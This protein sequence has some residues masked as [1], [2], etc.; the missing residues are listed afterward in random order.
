VDIVKCTRLFQGE[1]VKNER[2]RSHRHERV[3]LV[4]DV[5]PFVTAVWTLS[6]ARACSRASQ[7][8]TSEFARTVMKGLS[9][10]LSP[11]VNHVALPFFPHSMLMT[12]AKLVLD[13][14]FPTFTDTMLVLVS[15]L[16]LNRRAFAFPPEAAVI[17]VRSSLTLS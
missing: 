11:S 7:S 15:I 3:K 6:N 17:A 10:S 2:I 4:D 16:E 12:C 8:K 9:S 1:S 13:D 14:M 5:S